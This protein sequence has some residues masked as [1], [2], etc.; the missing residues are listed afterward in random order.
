MSEKFGS[1]GETVASTPHRPTAAARILDRRR[2]LGAA[3]LAGLAAAGSAGRV[4]AAPARP[5][6]A[7]PAPRGDDFGL[8]AHSFGARGDGKTDDTAAIQKALDAAGKQ[9]GGVVRLPVGHYLLHGSLRVPECVTLQGVFHTAQGGPERQGRLP[10]WRGLSTRGGGSVL[11]AVGGRGKAD[12]EPLLS[13]YG[14]SGVYGLTIYYPEQTYPPVEYPWTIRQMFADVSVQDVLLVNAWQGVDCGTVAGHRHYIRNLY[15]QMLKTGVFIDKCCDT[16]RVENVHIWPFGSFGAGAAGKETGQF[17]QRELTAFLIGRSDSEQMLDCSVCPCHIGFHFIKTP[18]P[19][20][21]CHG[22][23]YGN[24]VGL[25]AEGCGRAGLVVDDARFPGLL[26]TNSS[27]DGPIL[28]GPH[29]T[30][31]VSL[32]NCSFWVGQHR[33]VGLLRGQGAASFIGCTFAQWGHENQP[34]FLLDGGAATISNCLFQ[35][36]VP[37]KEIAVRITPHAASAVITGNTLTGRKLVIQ[38]APG[39]SPQ[40]FHIAGNVATEG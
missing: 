5:S 26:I 4:T 15:G 25:D 18:G 8:N 21:G 36:P 32:H 24:F 39:L 20:P 3:A 7:A 35:R 33:H 23:C 12:G 22:P 31:P 40:R 10:V 28:L 11:L 1:G 29:N 30:G 27:F 14:S 17:I 38:R 34:A 16:G 13:L 9:G 19:Y 2:F 6:H 37:G